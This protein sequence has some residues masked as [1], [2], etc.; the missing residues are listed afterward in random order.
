MVALPN[1]LHFDAQDTGVGVERIEYSYDGLYRLTAADY[2]EDE[3]LTRGYDYAYDL[4]GNRLNTSL[5]DGVDTI[6]T[7]FTYNSANQMVTSRA[8]NW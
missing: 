6:S 4:M 3:T 5:F 7:T 8:T 1:R 2:F